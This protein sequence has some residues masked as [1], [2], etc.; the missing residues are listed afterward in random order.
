MAAIYGAGA[1]I[2]AA[3]AFLDARVLPDLVPSLYEPS[4]LLNGAVPKAFGLQVAVLSFAG[5]QVLM[6]GMKVGG[7]RKHY[8]ALAQKDGEP[9]AETRYALPNLYV[10]GESKH[11]RLL[12]QYMRPP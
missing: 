3:G 11:V 1:A 2:A 4:P 6:F 9:N 8:M 12:I 5:L 10:S 7:K